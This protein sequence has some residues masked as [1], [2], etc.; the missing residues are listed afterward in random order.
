MTPCRLHSNYLVLECLNSNIPRYH[1]PRAIY[2]WPQ[3]VDKRGRGVGLVILNMKNAGEVV[4]FSL[5]KQIDGALH[6]AQHNVAIRG[7]ECGT[8]GNVV[9]VVEFRRAVGSSVC[10]GYRCLLVGRLCTVG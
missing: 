3:S 10:R 5:V 4:L 9:L 6:P 8:F 7:A 2:R 1:C